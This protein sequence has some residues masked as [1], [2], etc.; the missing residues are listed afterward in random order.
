MKEKENDIK[1]EKEPNFIIL[2][3]QGTKTSKNN[4]RCYLTLKEGDHSLRFN[5]STDSNLNQQKLIKTISNI[6]NQ[7]KNMNQSNSKNSIIEHRNLLINESIE[8]K[9]ENKKD[10]NDIHLNC[11]KDYENNQKWGEKEDTQ[12]KINNNKDLSSIIIEDDKI[13]DNCHD[14]IKKSEI[15]GNFGTN[16]NEK[17][18]RTQLQL[19]KKEKPKSIQQSDKAEISKVNSESDNVTEFDH[20]LKNIL[21]FRYDN[22]SIIKGDINEKE[23]IENELIDN[24][25][26]IIIDSKDNNKN[27][28]YEKQ[29]ENEEKIIFKP[30]IIQKNNFIG[31]DKENKIN[32]KNEKYEKENNNDL[33][34]QDSNISKSNNNNNNLIDINKDN[35]KKSN[36]DGTM[37]GEDINENKNTLSIPAI[38]LFRNNTYNKNIENKEKDHDK[39]K[40]KKM[41]ISV[42]R[43]KMQNICNP[44]SSTRG[45][46]KSVKSIKSETIDSTTYFY[47]TMHL[48][49]KNCYICEKPF[50]LSS[51]FCAD[52]GIHYLCRKCLKNYYEEY[53]E[54]QN[55]ID[56][57]K[58]PFTKCNRK[59]NYEIIQNI[60]SEGH[61]HLY[62]SKTN[63]DEKFNNNDINYNYNNITLSSKNNENSI[64]MY[65]EKHV[66][67]VNTN[68]N[69]FMFKKS[70]DIFCP[71]CLNPNLFSKT[72]N[73]FIKCLN[74][75]NKICK[76]CLKE[77]K[78]L[79]LNIRVEGYC[80]IYF[81]RDP[82]ED[83]SKNYLMNFLLQLLFVIAMYLFMYSGTY[84]L[85][86][87]KLKEKWGLDDKRKNCLFY[88]KKIIIFLIVIIFVII[89]SPVIIFFYPFFP[90]FIALLDY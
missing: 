79:H 90:A 35:N 77:Y 25:K 19:N 84:L 67:D 66:L 30:N 58:C 9:N 68:M 64:K 60:I 70:K 12:D 31:D 74:C 87:N 65:S 55:K 46:L 7:M 82:D 83:E 86:S 27:E 37:V 40:L 76:Y 29:N 51:L 5:F 33:I 50:Y 42:I 59:I 38:A 28:K 61:Q 8:D 34:N 21:K 54:S 89:C 78:D 10:S 56:F 13:S 62:E 48:M 80:K 45:Q 17:T 4:N 3:K 41:P 16:L 22:G 75:G 85:L 52:C 36:D 26:D 11:N 14:I 2:T 6:R 49:Q 24:D 44:Q 20:K 18:V 39:K 32:K 72:S 47:R 57:L 63:A 81:R 1:K 15:D 43:K 53:I 69:F 23:E 73:H 71:K 88:F